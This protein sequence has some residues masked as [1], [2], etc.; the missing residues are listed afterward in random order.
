VL[1]SRGWS[2]ISSRE[3]RERSVHI[4]WFEQEP[5]PLGPFYVP[6]WVPLQLRLS[7]LDL[8]HVLNGAYTYQGRDIYDADRNE[9]AP[10]FRLAASHLEWALAQHAASTRRRTSEEDLA[11][12][13]P[14]NLLTINSSPQ[15]TEYAARSG[16][17]Q[18][19]T[20]PGPS[21]AYPQSPP[22]TPSRRSIEATTPPLSRTGRCVVVP[23]RCTTL[24]RRVTHSSAASCQFFPVPLGTHLH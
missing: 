7:S 16:F 4:C 11:I 13:S 23:F 8:V 19:T 12:L 5:S 22:L 14:F 3:R 10:A 24:R 20:A 17:S 6:V 2:T 9:L 1:S 21:S 15:Q 18:T